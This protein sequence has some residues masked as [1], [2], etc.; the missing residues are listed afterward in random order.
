MVKQSEQQ[1]AVGSSRASAS[2]STAPSSATVAAKPARASGSDF[3]FERSQAYAAATE[4]A[5]GVLQGVEDDGA[6]GSILRESAIK[7]VGE[8]ASAVATSRD[9]LPDRLQGAYDRAHD[10]AG[11]FVLHSET[12]AMPQEQRT[13]LRESLAAVSGL[14][15]GLRRSITQ[16]HN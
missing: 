11:I 2:S 7:L 12:A 16:G 3:W 9:R 1:K 10:V 8:V 6:G 14:L 5:R 13:Q 15:F 4:F